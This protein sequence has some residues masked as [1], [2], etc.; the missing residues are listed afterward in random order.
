ME[1]ENEGAMAAVVEQV[2]LLHF[3][4]ANKS[5][6]YRTTGRVQVKGTAPD[7][8]EPFSMES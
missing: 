7:W 6:Q 2:D 8:P 4:K 3:G 5:K 1:D